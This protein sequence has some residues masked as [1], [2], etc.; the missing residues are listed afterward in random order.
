MYSLRWRLPGSGAFLCQLAAS[1]PSLAR[2]FERKVVNERQTGIQN[3]RG[4]TRRNIERV[5][6]RHWSKVGDVEVPVVIDGEPNTSH[7][8]EGRFRVHQVDYL[9]RL[10]AGRVNA[11]H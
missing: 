5:Y 8:V 10:C 6:R 3:R 11:D 4:H 7:M 9:H 2:A 1:D